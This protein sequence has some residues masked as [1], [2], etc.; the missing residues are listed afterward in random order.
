MADYILET[1]ENCALKIETSN[2]EGQ[3]YECSL[4]SSTQTMTRQI[5]MKPDSTS[6]PTAG[7]MLYYYAVRAQSVEICDDFLDWAAEN[8]LD[9]SES[10][11][12]NDYRTL[13]SDADDLK[14]LLG[15][16]SYDNLLSALAIDQAIRAARPR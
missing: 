5:E 1:I 12:L 8:D 7:Q 9:A 11:V 2:I 15:T 6:G 16:T 14:A 3:L 4:V 10:A 13:V